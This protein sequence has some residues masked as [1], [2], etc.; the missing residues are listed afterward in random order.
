MACTLAQFH[1]HP[2]SNSVL[3]SVNFS[4]GHRVHETPLLEGAARRSL[5]HPGEWLQADGARREVELRAYPE[6]LSLGRPESLAAAWRLASAAR[7]RL[8]LPFSP[9][10]GPCRGRGH[11]RSFR[12][13]PRLR[14][15]GTKRGPRGAWA[16]DPRRPRSTRVVREVR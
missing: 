4:D 7:G 2:L 9:G 16:H 15:S 14:L 3:D 11:P 6:G 13:S 12:Y 5:S 10:P 1:C 8:G